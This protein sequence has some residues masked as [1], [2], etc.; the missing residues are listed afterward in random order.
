MFDKSLAAKYPESFDPLVPQELVYSGQCPSFP[1]LSSCLG[2][3]Q[4]GH[5][6]MLPPVYEPEAGL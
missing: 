1:P 4:R 3:V 6:P 2:F 5:M